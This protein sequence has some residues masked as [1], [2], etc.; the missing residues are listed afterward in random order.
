MNLLPSLSTYCLFL[1]LQTSLS[2]FYSLYYQ[3]T[4]IFTY[5][6]NSGQVYYH[7]IVKILTNITLF[8]CFHSLASRE[9]DVKITIKNENRDKTWS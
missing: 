3:S 8:K 7:N 9:P 4:Y 5:N 1:H 2:V 6:I